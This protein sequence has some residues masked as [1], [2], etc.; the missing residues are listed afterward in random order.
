[1]KKIQEKIGLVLMAVLVSN[2]SFGQVRM[3][4]TQKE[5]KK[6]Y[7]VSLV[8][9][10]DYDF[11]KEIVGSIQLTIKVPK[12]SDF[13]VGGLISQID[14]TEW[15]RNNTLEESPLASKYNYYSFGV[16]PLGPKVRLVKGEELNLFSFQNLGD[17]KTPVLL[18]DNNDEILPIVESKLSL[19]MFNNISIHKRNSISNDYIGNIGE[20]DLSLGSNKEIENRI[21]INNIFPNP[22]KEKVKL[23]WSNYLENI[24]NLSIAIVNHSGVELINQKIEAKIGV[25]ENDFNIG[26][27]PEGTYLIHIKNGTK[28]VSQSHRVFVVK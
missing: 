21:I 13:M 11:P 1:M 16:E 23:V 22:A 26:A 8:S 25:N 3:K 14:E 4:I 24:T 5:D 17:I 19:D 9:E 10:R 28:A 18:I 20:K 7:M 2:L 15:L 27:L 12:G 6:T